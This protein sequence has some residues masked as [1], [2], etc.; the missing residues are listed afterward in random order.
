[1]MCDIAERELIKVD[2]AALALPGD[3]NTSASTLF[4]GSH[5]GLFAG[6]RSWAQEAEKDGINVSEMGLR[7]QE[8]RIKFS[9]GVAALGTDDQQGLVGASSLEILRNET[10]GLEAT[11]IILPDDTTRE[12]FTM[13]SET[14]RSKLGHL[15]P[16]GKVVC[17]VWH[18]ENC[19]EWDL[20]KDKYPGGG[21][22]R[23]NQSR[24]FEFW[25]EERVL[26]ECFV[27]MKL[28][29]S[30]ITLEGDIVVLDE[31]NQTHC[32]FYTWLPNEL[33]M[34]NKPKEVRWLAKGLPNYEEVVEIKGVK[35][36]GQDKNQE[37]DEFDDE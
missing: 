13:H 8:A 6:D 22:H 33:W 18:A 20:P 25:V 30:I 2:A 9:T 17:K 10:T 35:K 31:V 21:P 19:D 36:D 11:A 32:S 27:G 3:F 7:E 28:D 4:G 23:V 5:A 34:D 1:M 12:V 16:L 14:V 15:E 24:N 37:H 29:A 26:V